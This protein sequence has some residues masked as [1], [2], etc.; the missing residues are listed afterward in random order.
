MTSISK[1]QEGFNI[2][3]PMNV[4]NHI[5]KLTGKI[6]MVISIGAEKALD[7]IQYAFMIEVREKV[8]LE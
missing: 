1:M 8:E 5:K 4:I 7:I 2:H 6:H 3:K